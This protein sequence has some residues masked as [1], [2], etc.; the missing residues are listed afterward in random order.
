MAAIALD[1]GVLRVNIVSEHGEALTLAVVGSG[2]A[3]KCEPGSAP[4][5]TAENRHSI[6]KLL[7][8][9]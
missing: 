6:V 5:E 4:M 9:Q 7:R 2:R 1:R 3:R 8:P